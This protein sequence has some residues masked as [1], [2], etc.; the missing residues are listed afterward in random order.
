M[1]SVSKK[2]VDKKIKIICRETDIRV[3]MDEFYD[4]YPQVEAD[5]QAV[6]PQDLTSDDYLE[7]PTERPEDEQWPSQA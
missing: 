4:N 1:K 3:R 6:L 5:P 7:V 2:F